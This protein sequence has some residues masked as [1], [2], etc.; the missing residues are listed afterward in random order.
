MKKVS[1]IITTYN[2]VEEVKRA[3]ESVLNQT[4]RDF[5]LIVV[6]DNGLGTSLQE[7]TESI[8]REYINDGKLSYIAHKENSN[9]SVARNTGFKNSVGEYVMFLD[10]DDEFTPD[11]IEKQLLTL[12][13]SDSTW[14]A[15]YCSFVKIE[16]S[17]RFYERVRA[18]KRGY[19]LYNV[20]MHRPTLTTSNLMIKREAYQSIG[21]FDES[22]FRHQDWEFT[23]RL[24]EK[25]KITAMKDVGLITH[26]EFRTI[27]QNPGMFKE[28]REN[29]LNKMQ[30]QLNTLGTISRNRVIA[31]NRYDIVMH[32]LKAEGV[33]GFL[34]EYKKIGMGYYGIEFLIRRFYYILKQR[35]QSKILR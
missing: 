26:L 11:R 35:I 25:W 28:F 21:G 31:E 8:L 3:V 17:G 29:Y 19:M 34:R 14:G 22:F 12:E 2:G 20:M 27:P 23:A 24:A 4:Y 13:N 16:K 5:E 10:D 15:S 9:A 6:D 18:G 33:K 7:K 30:S 1:V 32:Y